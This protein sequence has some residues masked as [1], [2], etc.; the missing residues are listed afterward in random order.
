LDR[1]VPVGIIVASRGA[2]NLETWMSRERLITHPDFTEAVSKFDTDTA[3]WNLGVRKSQQAERDRENIANTSVLGF[4]QKV[5]ALKY[6]DSSW[7][8]TDYP[9]NMTKMGYPGF[10]GLVWIRKTIDV[11]EQSVKKEWKLF[12]PIKDQNDRIY[13]NGKEIAQGVSKLK[14]KIV[15]LPAGTLKK[16]INLLAIRMYIP[17]NKRIIGSISGMH[18]PQHFLNLLI[19][20][21]FVQLILGTRTIFIRKTNRKLEGVF[22]WP[23]K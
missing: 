1:K 7:A 14:E 4:D 21:W 19:P 22:I 17:Q 16:G 20:L 11:S 23:R 6:N 5:N 3:H 9:I 15:L 2:T 18:K 13:L 8:K 10:W 12:L